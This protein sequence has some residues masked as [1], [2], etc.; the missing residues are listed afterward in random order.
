MTKEN[1]T[2]SNGMQT[3]LVANTS[4][5]NRNPLGK[6]FSTATAMTKL[7]P[8]TFYAQLST[9]NSQQ[10]FVGKVNVKNFL[11]NANWKA[12]VYIP[13]KQGKTGSSNGYQRD[14]SKRKAEDFGR[15]I[16]KHPENFT[17]SSLYLNIRDTDTSRVKKTRVYENG[18]LYRITIQDHTKIWVVDG[19]HRLEGL[20]KQ[21]DLTDEEFEIPILLTV[22]VKRSE[23]MFQ[24]VTMNKARANVK[25]DLAERNLANAM[26]NDK[27]FK[28]SIMQRDSSFK[29]IE[30]IEN[31]VQIMDELSGSSASPWHKRISL[32]NPKKLKEKPSV[33]IDNVSSASFVDSLEP[34]M[35]KTFA[36]GKKQKPKPALA[37]VDVDIATRHIN[38]VWRGIKMVNPVM[39]ERK[40]ACY[41]VIQHT[42]GTMAIHLVLMKMHT[43]GDSEKLRKASA[44]DFKKLFNI[45]AIKDESLWDKGEKGEYGGKFTNYGTNKKSFNFI[46]DI[47]YKEVKKSKT[48]KNNYAD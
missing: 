47:L 15:F 16:N 43:N 37:D 20:A 41:F 33:K 39:F 42:I 18:E 6:Q 19:Q 25:V 14:V 3:L 36:G 35:K 23:E 27:T 8:L 46:A 26:K 24:F 12:D 10:I 4:M 29:D 31:A 28:M 17:A 21:L 40:N 32:P 7:M 9:Q 34:L 5:Q 11:E 44:E 1:N 13:D 22:G 45:E 38:A 30:F 48:W 2:K